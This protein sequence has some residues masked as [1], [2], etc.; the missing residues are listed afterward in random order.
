MYMYIQVWESSLFTGCTCLLKYVSQSHLPWESPRFSPSTEGA[1]DALS[2]V[3]ARCPNCTLLTPINKPLF[4][5]QP[6]PYAAAGYWSHR[7]IGNRII[8]S[9]ASSV[10][11]RHKLQLVGP[12]SVDC[13]A[14][15]D[16]HPGTGRW[17][18]VVAYTVLTVGLI[19]LGSVR[20]SS[21]KDAKFDGS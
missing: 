20:Q 6:A 14:I 1:I 15:D 16:H 4:G 5:F 7:P 21:L 3:P 18:T 10:L 13:V 17:S 12:G 9:A 2:V 19:L 11:F 8:P